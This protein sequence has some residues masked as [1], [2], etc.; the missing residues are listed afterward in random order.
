MKDNSKNILMSALRF[1]PLVICMICLGYYLF[2]GA[3][4][5]LEGLENFAPEQPHLAAVFLIFL[6]AFKSLSIFFP[7][8][9]LDILGGFLFEPLIALLVNSV[10]ILVELTVSYWTGRCSGAGFAEKMYIK[11]P[12]IREII[13]IEESD[14]FFLAFLLHAVCFL[15]CDV[16]SMCLG[17]RKMSFPVFLAGS[18]LGMLPGMIVTTLLGT[19]IEDPSSPMF[20]FFV[21]LIAVISV[22]SVL[23]YYFWRRNKSR[24]PVSRN[25]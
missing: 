18:F 13:G 20:W 17:A 12:K 7:I 22:L 11:Y 14:H 8:A 23:I 4:L 21:G 10:G 5:S 1:V 24:N 16:V 3:D 2:S 6:Y 25:R 9:V 19:S 15:P